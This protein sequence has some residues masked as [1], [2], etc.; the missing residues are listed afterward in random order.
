MVRERRRERR[1]RRGERG[2]WRGIGKRCKTI[3]KIISDCIFNNISLHILLTTPNRNYL[4]KNLYNN[5]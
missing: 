3:H 5:I 1:R 4:R 2:G